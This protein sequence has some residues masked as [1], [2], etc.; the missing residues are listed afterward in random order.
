MNN[1]LIVDD[2]YLSRNKLSGIVDYKS[3]GFNVIGEV[4]NGKEAM[5]FIEEYPVNVVFTDVAMPEM[6]GLE[7]AQCIREAYPSIKVVIM[8][9]YSDFD[10]IKRA[11]S[12]NVCDY[13]LKHS[14][15][16]DSMTKLLRSLS[17]QLTD[18][19]YSSSVFEE[20]LIK[21][22]EYRNKIKNAIFDENSHFTP[23]NSLILIMRIDS[24]RLCTPIYTL[25]EI[26]IL[27]QNICNLVAQS[28]SN[29]KKFVI[30][31]HEDTIV[32]YLPFPSADS[33]VAVMQTISRLIR[34][35][36]ASV[37]KFFG[38]NTAWGMSCLSSID[39]TL[40]QCWKEAVQML[41]ATPFSAK[42]APNPALFNNSVYTLSIQQEKLLLSAVSDLN[43]QQIIRC[44]EEI[45]SEIDEETQT[46]ILIGDLISIA[47][48]FCSSYEI[49]FPEI[50]APDFFL[51]VSAKLKWCEDM[52]KSVIDTYINTKS[53]KNHSRYIGAVINYIE[54]NYSKNISLKDMAAYVGISEQHLST[55]FKDEVGKSPSVYLTEYRIERAKTL[56]EKNEINLKQLYSEVGFNSYNY[57]FTVFKKITGLTPEAYRKSRQ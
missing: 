10:Y 24:K 43:L 29:I 25:S 11:F 46:D 2:E 34:Q 49:D 33:E 14:I 7:L 53:K 26:D 19:S 6:D 51:S 38:F 57:F 16:A 20:N 45:F 52:F 42:K 28:I 1:I 32:L 37:H 27:Y 23:I 50:S 15:S 22:E 35:I 9:N 13:L 21:E 39:Y 5:H 41:N 12:A 44:L 4:T 56:L 18:T 31:R 17:L 30:F 55:V 47:A 48:K 54:K 8:S 36:T 40:N 3:L